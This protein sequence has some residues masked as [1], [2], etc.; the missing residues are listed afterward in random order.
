LTC[1]VSRRRI[2]RSPPEGDRYATTTD[3]SAFL[4]LATPALAVDGVLE[5]ND[6]CALNGGCFPGDLM[7]YPV[8]ITSPGSFRLT[9]N[10]TVT[11]PLTDAIKVSSDGVSVDLNGF[12][13]T[14]PGSGFPRGVDSTND[15]VKVSNGTI[16]SM[17]N[18]VQLIG[19][20]A[21]VEGMSLVD[22]LN[23]GLFV[24][25]GALVTGNTISGNGHSGVMAGT[26]CVLTRNAVRNNGLY[27][28]SA[29]S[30]SVVV[31]NTLSGNTEW[32]LQFNSAYSGYG[33]N[34]LT[35]NNGGSANVQLNIGTELS[36][37]ICGFDTTCP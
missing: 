7:G 12:V 24:G 34:V 14:G 10:L 26:S 36:T 4:A 25:N 1:G 28:I 13:I 8:T 9:G 17:Y 11:D 5:I 3:L 15:N 16:Q 6:T 32:G 30:G 20:G 23:T 18:A 29:A 35:E 27:G 33:N 19:E 37:N 2:E 31:E 21:H 22:N